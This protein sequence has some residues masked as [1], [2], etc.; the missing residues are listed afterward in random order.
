MFPQNIKIFPFIQKKLSRNQNRVTKFWQILRGGI[1]PQFSSI[2]GQSESKVKA[3]WKQNENKIAG[4]RNFLDFQKRE[5]FWM[6]TEIFEN[7]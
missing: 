7:K 1:L 3:K 2:F 6:G 5:D 4:S